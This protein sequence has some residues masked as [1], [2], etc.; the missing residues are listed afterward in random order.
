ME[1]VPIALITV[2]RTFQAVLY[3][4]DKGL[5]GQNVL[6]LVVIDSATYVS[7]HDQFAQG[8]MISDTRAHK[9]L[10]VLLAIAITGRYFQ[11]TL[12]LNP[13]NDAT[14]LKLYITDKGT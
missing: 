3:T 1:R 12:L 6:Q 8:P 9:I 7:A 4:V 11:F 13:H 10:Y 5:R 14:L 2:C